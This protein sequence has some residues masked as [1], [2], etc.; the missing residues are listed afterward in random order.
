[1]TRLR[2]WVL[3]A[4][5]I[6][7]A[8]AGI[9]GVNLFDEALTPEARALFERPPRAF[10]RDS[11]W[12]LLAGF[13]APAGQDPRAYAVAS[14]PD[15]V[16]RAAGRKAKRARRGDELEVRAA[17][18]LLCAPQSQ[19]CVRAFAPKPQSIDELAQDNRLL[20]ARYDELLRASGMADVVHGLDAHD[21]FFPSAVLLGVQ[22]IRMSQVGAAAARGRYDEAIAWLETDAAFQRRWLEEADTMLSKMIA[23]RGLSRMHVLA[24]QV[25]RNAPSLSPAQWD[26]LLRV[27]EPLTPRQ[28]GL[29]APVRSEAILFA[30]MVEELVAAPRATSKVTG[31]TPAM[32]DLASLALR[33]NATLN[34]AFPLY[35]AWMDLDAIETADLAP[36]I[37]RNRTREREHLTP[38]WTWSYNHAGRRVVSEGH[39]DVSE[40]VYRLRD[41]DALARMMR[42]AIGLRAAGV[43]AQAADAF[44]GREA[45]C[46]DPYLA[47]PFAWDAAR[48]EL[49]FTASSETTAQRFSGTEGSKR[50][51]F[52][53]Y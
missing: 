51:F 41:L 52:A 4:A 11:G 13:N 5:T 9:V 49:S 16:E 37:E 8:I 7:L 23:V 50:V 36:Q 44:I 35:A 15:R 28:R 6:V 30:E 34:F 21:A 46:R 42:C 45:G 25:A 29:A 39:Y 31:A 18:E 12:A 22:R 17:S 40:Y 1:M 32:A 10:A 47:R 27:V 19:D 2:P 20:L 26:A 14:A 43:P 38:D 48:G 53:A 33:R 3:V 24:G